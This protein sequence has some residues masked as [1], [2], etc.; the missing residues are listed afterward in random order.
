MPDLPPNCCSAVLLTTK[1]SGINANVIGWLR[2][3]KFQL[4]SLFW[5]GNWIWGENAK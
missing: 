3:D 2:P 1:E 5:S 4:D